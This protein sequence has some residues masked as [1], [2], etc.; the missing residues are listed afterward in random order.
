MCTIKKKEMVEENISLSVFPPSGYLG[1]SAS[2]LSFHH[3]FA[4]VSKKMTAIFSNFCKCSSKLPPKLC[5][6]STDTTE[7]QSV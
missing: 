7:Y 1:V 5:T 3:H 6:H 4:L 2:Q